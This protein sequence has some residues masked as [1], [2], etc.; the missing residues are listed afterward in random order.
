MSHREHKEK[1]KTK[2]K[3]KEKKKVKKDKEEK[4]AGY[5]RLTGREPEAWELIIPQTKIALG[6][7]GSPKADVQLGNSVLIS[8]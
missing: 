1:Q 5:F 7:T 2:V 4:N 8:R 6:R 3:K